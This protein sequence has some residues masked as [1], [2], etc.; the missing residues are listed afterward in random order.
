MVVSIESNQNLEKNE[1]QSNKENK[2]FVNLEDAIKIIGK[3]KIKIFL[4]RI[5][6][7][8]SNVLLT[9][10]GKFHYFLI[11]VSGIFMASAFYETMSVN[12]I[13]PISECDLNI[14]SL[15]Q[16]GIVSGCWFFGEFE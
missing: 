2:Q 1:K 12:Y 5:S 10:F 13:L 11:C 14:S 15:Q 16:Y 3:I 6:H 9:G 8:H 7:S 4:I